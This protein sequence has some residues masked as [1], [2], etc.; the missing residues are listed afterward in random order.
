[1]FWNKNRDRRSVITCPSCGNRQEESV[2]AVSTYC[3]SCGDYLRLSK[4]A[5]QADKGTPSS[6]LGEIELI[7]DKLRK[8]SAKKKAV[9]TGVSNEKIL[10]DLSRPAKR[11]TASE[12]GSKVGKAAVADPIAESDL[13][14]EI[15]ESD[16][17]A[18]EFFGLGD[19][20]DEAPKDSKVE[21]R[22]SAIRQAEEANT[23]LREGSI[24]AMIGDSL[25]DV[26]KPIAVEEKIKL[27][28]DHT[29]NRR[30]RLFQR[31]PGAG[32]LMVRCFSCFHEQFISKSAQSTQCDRCN[33]YIA[34]ESYEIRDRFVGELKTRGDVVIY[35]RGEVKNCS[36]ACGNMTVSGE[37]DAEVDCSGKL[38]LKKSAK[39][40][41]PVFSENFIVDSGVEV[42]LVDVL[43]TK[44]AV[45]HGILKGNVTCEGIV[46]VSKNGKIMGDVEAHTVDLYEGG[47]LTG[48][49]LLDPD[50]KLR[51]P[52][53]SGD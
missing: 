46:K 21:V 9:S 39:I 51:P 44:N 4:G 7:E 27:P 14:G 45:I 43:N 3:L 50:L 28:A 25:N 48:K 5:V 23:D 6:G 49:M 29:G 31:K 13:L 17:S 18:G 47:S 8:K 16:I 38:H 53:E 41:G 10:D 32:Q 30:R 12:K 34:L 42:D 35:R 24:G 26:D 20:A 22:N 37:L 15:E 2:M 11:N 1:M 36:V 19:K 40:A 33:T 52:D